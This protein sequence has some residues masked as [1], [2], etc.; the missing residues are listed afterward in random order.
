MPTENQSESDYQSIERSTPQHVGDRNTKQKSYYK[1]RLGCAI[2]FTIV[3]I[4]L[5]AAPIWATV[6][7]H[8]D[9]TCNSAIP[10][11]YTRS[12]SYSLLDSSFTLACFKPSNITI[13]LQNEAASLEIYEVPCM[14]IEKHYFNE[15]YSNAV[16]MTVNQPAPLFGEDF[17]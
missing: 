8:H 4:F 7:Y 16:N 17:S 10:G 14:S 11:A 12:G 6:H 1:R 2:V 15:S 9:A 5:L 13:S 3:S